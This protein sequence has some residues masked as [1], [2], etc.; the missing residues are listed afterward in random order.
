[1]SRPIS[2][3]LL[4]NYDSFTYNL[5][6]EL[7]GMGMELII[8]RNSVSAQMI[9]SQ[10][11]QKAENSEVLLLLSPGPG[12]PSQAGC[13]LELIELVKGQF[14]VL[15]ICLGHQAI[16][17]S[18]GGKVIR[19]EQ[20]MHGKASYIQHDNSAL[21]CGLANPLPVARYHSLVVSDIPKEL[22]VIANFEGIPMCV[23][24]PAD[25]MLGFQFHPES[26]LTSHGSQLLE[27]SIRYLTQKA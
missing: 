22:N 20:V 27:Q 16:V 13:L 7:R 8:Y 18:Y 15:G 2:V 23:Y 9:Y 17:K 26:I 14:P 19:A 21:F 6:D 11:Q 3:F 24:H 25:R 12:E 10:M 4:D 1:M 5:V